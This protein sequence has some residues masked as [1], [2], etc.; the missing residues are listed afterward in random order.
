MPKIIRIKPSEQIQAFNDTCGRCGGSGQIDS[1]G[2]G[3]AG[4]CPVCSGK[5]YMPRFESQG[6]MQTNLPTSRSYAGEV[7]TRT[8]VRSRNK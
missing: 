4:P 7:E 2:I 6:A 8:S 3:F 5:G 1:L